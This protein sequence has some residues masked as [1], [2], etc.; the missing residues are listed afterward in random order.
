MTLEIRQNQWREADWQGQSLQK[1]KAI[2]QTRLRYFETLIENGLISD[3]ELYRVLTGVSLGFRTASNVS[4]TIAQGISIIPD[5]F[6]GFPTTQTWVP[7]GTKLGGVL[8]IAA[9]V[10]NTVADINGTTASL[11]LTE[12]G[13]ERREDEW[14]HQVEVLRIEIEQIE[15]LLVMACSQAGQIFGIAFLIGT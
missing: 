11:R 7:I 12:G 2:A 4:E 9:R 13:W 3:E 15:Q 1:A 14:Q 10:L 6:P 8:S 5:L